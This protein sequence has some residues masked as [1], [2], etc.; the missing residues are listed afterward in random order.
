MRFAPPYELFSRYFPSDPRRVAGIERRRDQLERVGS[1]SDSILMEI[2][3]T[4]LLHA[5]PD[6]YL[7]Q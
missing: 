6:I 3:A 1:V 2:L 7:I 5:S 4:N